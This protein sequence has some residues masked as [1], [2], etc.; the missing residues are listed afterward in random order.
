[1]RMQEPTLAGQFFVEQYGLAGGMRQRVDAT[2]D[3]AE[4]WSKP[5]G[6]PVYCGEFGVHR[7]YAD[8]AM[9]AQWLRRHAGGDGEAAHRVG[10]VGLSGQLRR[11]DEEERNDDA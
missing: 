1:M 9:R 2:V 10:D 7:P 3:F 6:V 11:G 4:R 5:Y 8:A